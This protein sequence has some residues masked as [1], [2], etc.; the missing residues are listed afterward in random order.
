MILKYSKAMKVFI[1][2]EQVKFIHKKLNLFKQKKNIRLKINYNKENN[3]IIN[4]HLKIIKCSIN[5][6]MT[7]MILLSIV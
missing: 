4:L 3:K 6:K 1:N 2:L 7:K 5:T